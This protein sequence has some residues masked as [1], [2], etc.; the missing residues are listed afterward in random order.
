MAGLDVALVDVS[1]AALERGMSA[2]TA[3]LERL[4][5]KK[6]L[7]A[8]ESAGVRSRV[9]ACTD[10]G[11]VKNVSIVIEAATENL[12]LKLRI[13]KQ[14]SETVPLHAVIASN[15]SSISIT[16][17]AAVVTRPERFIGIHFFNPVPLMG[18][19]EVISGLLTSEETAA[20]A[21]Q[22][23]KTVGKA[24]VLVHN[25]PGFVVNRILVPARALA[26]GTCWKRTHHHGAGVGKSWPTGP[27]QGA[28]SLLPFSAAYAR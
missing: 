21:Q 16:Q 6:T 17:L 4:V 25:S 20:S 1:E 2:I 14:L 27:H 23:A 8:E 12:E 9:R 10:Y 18:L 15:T 26:R 7:S 3:G 19:V 5:K 24:P 22:F 11:G 28:H 13:L